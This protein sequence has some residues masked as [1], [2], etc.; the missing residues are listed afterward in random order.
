MSSGYVR[1]VLQLIYESYQDTEVEVE[2]SKLLFGPSTGPEEAG[3]EDEGTGIATRMVK[4]GSRVRS[5]MLIL[6]SLMSL[7]MSI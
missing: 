1:F 3:E 2:K 5:S 4:A 6:M 7:T